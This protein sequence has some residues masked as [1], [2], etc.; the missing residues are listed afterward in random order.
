MKLCRACGVNVSKD[1]KNRHPLIGKDIC[2]T[3]AEFASSAVRSLP[4]PSGCEL[5]LDVKKF[6]AGYV[7]QRCY[8]EL[9]SLH[10]LQKKLRDTKDTITCKIAKV[11]S[12]TSQAATGLC[13]CKCKCKK[14]TSESVKTC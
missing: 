12:L 11:A 7:C 13:K 4:S 1:T 14:P 9:T 10:T 3:L 2:P 8:R 6:E 5:C